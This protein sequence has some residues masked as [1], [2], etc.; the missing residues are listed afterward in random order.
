MQT[1]DCCSDCVPTCHNHRYKVCREHQRHASL[2]AGEYGMHCKSVH[3]EEN[4]SH[5]IGHLPQNR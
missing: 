1:I 3:I 5:K 4:R 2:I